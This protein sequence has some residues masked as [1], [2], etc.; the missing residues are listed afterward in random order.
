LI[1]KKAFT[2]SNGDI[3]GAIAFLREKGLAR[4]SK[5][6]SAG[7]SMPE[8]IVAVYHHFDKRMAVIVEA[9][10]ETDFVAKND[11]FEE[12]ARD[13]ALH[14]SSA[15]PKFVA[16]EEIPADA[17]QAQKDAELKR[18]V[19]E[20]KSEDEANGSLDEAMNEFYKQAVLMEQAYIKD[21]D[22]TIEQ[23]LKEKVSELGESIKVARFARFA[24]GENLGSEGDEGEE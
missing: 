5:K 11:K 7:R 10:C 2:E 24:I 12:F 17:L 21:E 18:M 14:T 9:G 6:L 13:L 8:G 15:K 4:A 23:L 19:A 1:A 3:E 20:G 22:K 16:R